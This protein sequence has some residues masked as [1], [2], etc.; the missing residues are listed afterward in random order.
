MT[1]P[2]P[3]AAGVAW[4]L[5]GCLLLAAIIHLLPLAGLTSIATLQRLYDLPALDA[6]SVLLLQHRAW[7]F[8]LFGGAL[9][10]AIWR[11]Q[12]RAPAITL[13]LLSDIGFLLLAAW[14]W[15]LQPALQRVVAFDAAAIVLLGVAAWCTAHAKR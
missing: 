6:G 13:V 12:W 2:A 9:L 5:R 10:W 7:M 3:R 1:R 4:T 15:P 14:A 8:G 11:P